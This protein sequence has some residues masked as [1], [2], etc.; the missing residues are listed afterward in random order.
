MAFLRR[1]LPLRDL[2]SPLID[3]LAGLAGDWGDA[4]VGGELVAGGEPVGV[5]DLGEHA[6]S[7]AGP[8]V[9]H[10]Q[11]QFTDTVGSED[12]FDLLGEAFAAL[13]VRVRHRLVRAV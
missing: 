8:D 4:G 7:G 10:R 2:A 9:G 3:G 11:E 1:W 5:A 12:L 6:C 13:L